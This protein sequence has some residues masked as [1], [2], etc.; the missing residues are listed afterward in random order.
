VLRAGEGIDWMRV[1][2]K[3]LTTD[4][5]LAQRVASGDEE[6]LQIFFERYAD[7]LFTFIFHH[8]DSNKDEAEEV[9]QM[10]LAAS[11]NS[12]MA[13]RGDGQLFTWLCA[14]ARHKIIDFR[15][16]NRFP[17][18]VFSDLPAARLTDLLDSRPL[19]EEILLQR[20]THVLVITALAALPDDYRIV[21]LE[22]YIH[23]R[24]VGEISRLLGRSYKATESLLSRART[25]LRTAL[26]R[27][28]E[29]HGETR[30]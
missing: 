11:V 26:E 21:L 22:R 12:M 25:A 29:E 7:P 20:S 30:R 17:A 4:T 1:K 15:R 8:L 16:R 24:S 14:I 5:K 19:P 18:D 3:K 23:E 13:Y 27:L 28:E 6:A 10:T 9:W 2:K